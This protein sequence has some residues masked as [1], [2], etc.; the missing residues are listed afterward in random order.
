MSAGRSVVVTGASTGIGLGTA[1]VA[2]RNGARVFGSVRKSADAERLRQE[3]GASFTPLLF[4]VTDQAAVQRAAAEVREHLQ[5]S[6]LSGLVNNAGVAVSGPALELSPD[7]FR[8]QLEVN[9]VGPFM[10]TQAFAPLLGKDRALQGPPGRIVNVSSVGGKMG[11]P[12]LGA[13]VASKHALEG[14]S[15]SLRRELMLYG[16][17][18]IVV[19]PGTVATPIW[20][21]ADKEDLAR[22]D[23]SDYREALHKFKDFMVKNGP[24]GLP[25]ERIGE[26]IW[27][28]LTGRSPKVRYAVVP[29]AFANWILPTTLPKRMV[30]RLIAGRLGL[31]RGRKPAP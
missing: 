7:D 9:V 13:Y 10:V 21:K 27:T 29:G 22:Y 5:G 18:V 2:L 11:A 26:V 30:D 24:T 8:K 25:P 31:V 12:F 17:D 15:E 6:T 19:G 20:D 1:K 4:D 3:L 16:I 23:R 14:W 28:A